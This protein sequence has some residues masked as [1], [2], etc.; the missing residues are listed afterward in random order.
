MTYR[1]AS[2]AKVCQDNNGMIWVATEDG[3]NRYDGSKFIVFRNIPG[4]STSLAK[5]TLSTPQMST[6]KVAHSSPY[7]GLQLHDPATD[8]FSPLAKTPDGQTFASAINDLIFR[9]NGEIIVIGNKVG[10][11]VKADN[12][13]IVIEPAFTDHPEIEYVHNGIEDIGGDL[14]LLKEEMG[15]YR[16]DSD[17]NIYRYFGRPATPYSPQLPWVA[18]V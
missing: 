6:V 3:L 11:I 5:A 9:K 13:S 12:K 16:L 4:D 14:W 15:T 18:T 17:N 2:S 8:T 7:A 10:R 1:A